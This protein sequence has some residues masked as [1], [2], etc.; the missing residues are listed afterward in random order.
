MRFVRPEYSYLIKRSSPYAKDQA[1]T[2]MLEK[3][4]DK[5]VANQIEEVVKQTGNIL[6]LPH[7]FMTFIRSFG[8][9]SDGLDTA[10]YTRLLNGD[11][12]KQ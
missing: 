6:V 9:F 8:C 11:I 12:N 5:N 4:I 3:I 2:Y 7:F 1:D 10:A